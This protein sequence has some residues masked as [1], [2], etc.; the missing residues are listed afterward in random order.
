MTQQPNQLLQPVTK[1]LQAVTIIV[2]LVILGCNKSVT[3]VTKDVTGSVTGVT[4]VT[5]I[6]TIYLPPVTTVV[7]D[8]IKCPPNQADTLLQVVT[9]VVTMPVA[10]VTIVRHKRDTVTQ[11]VTMPVTAVT[12]PVTP[13]TKKC[14]NCN[15]RCNRW[16]YIVTGFL[17]GF[18][19]AAAIA[20]LMSVKLINHGR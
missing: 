7:T 16:R 5:S 19:T 11:V 4:A 12:A 15:K 6:D 20:F 18:V 17:I 3:A 10:P 14:N 9:R 8:T 13:V 1:L 2:T